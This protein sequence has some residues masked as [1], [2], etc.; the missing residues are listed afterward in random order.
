MLDIRYA[1]PEDLSW[2]HEHDRDVSSEW[3]ERCITHREYIIALD[4]GQKTGFLRFSLF[5]GAIPYMDL[6][7]VNEGLQRQGI[8]TAL[9][10]F[11]EKE[12]IAKGAKTLLTSSVHDEIEPQAWHKQNGFGECGQLTFGEYQSTPEIFFVKNL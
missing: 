12:M 9:F 6:I 10:K 3:A 4:E 7:R 1:E 11:W 5:W 8:G 2:L